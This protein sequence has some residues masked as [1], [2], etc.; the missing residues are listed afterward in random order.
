MAKRHAT[1]DDERGTG[2]NRRTYLKMAGATAA[3]AATGFAGTGGAVPDDYDPGTVVNL[4]EQGLSNGD[5]ID[6]YLDEYAGNGVEVRVPEGEYDWNGNGFH[7]FASQNAG[8]IGEGEVILN[9]AAGEFNNNIRAEGG[10]LVIQNFTVR[11][12]VTDSRIRLE[13][14]SNGHI[15]VDNW[16]FPDGGEDDDRSRAFYAPRE[17]AGVLEIRNCYIRAFSDNGIYA[18]SPGYDN[19][20]HDGQVI[21]DSCVTHNINIAGIRV[22]STDSIVRNCVVINDDH[23]PE[24]TTGHNQRG[25]WV[26]GP[27]DDILIENCDIIHTY[28]GAGVPINFAR[29]GLDSSGHIENVRIRNDTSSIA[30]NATSAWSGDDIDVTGSGDLRVPD[31]FTNVCQGSDCDETSREVPDSG[32]DP[33][34]EPEGTVL[35]FVTTDSNGIEYTFRATGEISPLYT[36][37]DYSA[38]SDTDGAEENDDGSW[39]GY[40][41]TAGGSVHSGDSFRYQGDI[42]ELDVTGDVE[43]LTLLNDGEEVTQD[44]LVV[45]DDNNDD[46][47][48]DGNDDEPEELSNRL[49][50]DGTDTPTVASYSVDVTG[51]IE[52]NA[53]LSSTVDGGSRWDDI[54]DDIGDGSV[55]GVVGKGIDG[56]DYSGEITSVSVEGAVDITVENNDL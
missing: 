39:T 32:D 18:S 12:K 24:A 4:G 8:I 20:G 9:T 26:R 54:E 52:R 28:S 38:N 14:G 49:I 13:C 27:G 44:E 51:D 56:F 55:T 16:N 31:Q 43:S 35:S 21:I 48:N 46:D 53:S 1:D 29:D 37:E 36:R 22:G 15:L 7:G 47:N 6:P 41:A 5:V 42:V 17:H 2:F 40:G 50:I 34:A 33:T 3:V 25:I 30:C 23:S 45:D 19:G 11:G 10:S